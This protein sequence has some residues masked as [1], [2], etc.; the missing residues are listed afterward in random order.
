M[1]GEPEGLTFERLSQ[2]VVFGIKCDGRV[3]L[4]FSLRKKKQ[5][6]GRN[7]ENSQ[8]QNMETSRDSWM[9]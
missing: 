5:E 8:W 6:L 1:S 4:P 3:R 9:G 7:E 2:E